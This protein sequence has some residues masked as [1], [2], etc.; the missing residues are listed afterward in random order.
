MNPCIEQ[1]DRPRRSSKRFEII[2]VSYYQMVEA[3]GEPNVGGGVGQSRSYDPDAG[4][5]SWCVQDGPVTDAVDEWPRKLHVWDWYGSGAAGNW[6]ADG[7][8]ELADELG[9][10]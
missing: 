1:V 6:S 4:P 5:A 7:S 9:L 8:R 2:G 3:L 10:L